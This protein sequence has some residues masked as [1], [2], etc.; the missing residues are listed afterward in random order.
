MNLHLHGSSSIA[1]FEMIVGDNYNSIV[2]ALK[3]L[4]LII[5]IALVNNTKVGNMRLLFI[6]S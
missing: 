2:N 6:Y 4:E 3:T 1:Q 5:Q